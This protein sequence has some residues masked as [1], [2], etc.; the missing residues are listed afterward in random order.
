MN[1]PVA[2]GIIMCRN[3]IHSSTIANVTLPSS[4]AFGATSRRDVIATTTLS[5]CRRSTCYSCASKATASSPISVHG[6]TH[7]TIL[8]LSNCNYCE[9]MDQSGRVAA[10]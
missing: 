2:I 7:D 6:N 9:S 4:R 8:A 1:K 3:T 5:S 10:A